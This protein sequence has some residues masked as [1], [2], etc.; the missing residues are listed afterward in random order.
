MNKIPAKYRTIL[1]CTALAIVTIAAFWQVPFY[2]FIDFDDN[3]YVTANP[4]IQK[5]LNWQSVVW[6]FRTPYAA[7]WHPMTMLS[8]MLDYQLF[9]LN[10]FGYHLTNVLLHIANTLLLFIIL[11]EMTG[12][13]WKSAFVAAAFAL[14]SLHV[15]SVAWVSERKDV[16]ST[17]FWMLTMLAYMR[18]A[19]R[20]S[21][22]RYLL[23]L[24]V[25]ALGLMAKPMLVTLPFV[26]LLVD[27]WPLERLQF[28]RLAR[29]QEKNSAD[30]GH[31][32]S[33][34]IL[35]KVPFLALSAVFSVITIFTQKSEQ[36]LSLNLPLITRIGNAM[37]SYLAYIDKMVWPG[38]L[39]VFYPHPGSNLPLWQAAAAFAALAGISALA[40]RLAARHKYLPVGWLLFLGTLVPVIGLVQIHSFAM[41]DRFTYIPLTGLFII[42]AWGADDFLADGRLGKIMLGISAT[43]VLSALLICTSFQLRYWRNNVTL[44]EHAIRVT[45]NN[46]M[47]YYN[48]GVAYSK[49][50]RWQE[51]I[52]AYR[53]STRIKP[54]FDALYNLGNAY[55][56][57][58]RWQEAVEAYKQAIAIKP[59]LAQAYSNLGNSYYNLGRRMEAVEA[60]RQAIALKPD[61][62]EAH[63]NLGVA[64]LQ[65]GDKGSA[66]EECK[67]LKTLDAERAN[68]LFNLIQF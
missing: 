37:V 48:L 57:L 42:I 58:G 53:Q 24:G 25:F 55:S 26:L 12:A 3:V 32:W 36:T 22:S 43:A 46:S 60:Y 39:A 29:E 11:N 4:H 13:L 35:E 10:A 41:A 52:E 20:P 59:D 33:R 45:A 18:Y 23:T 14:H 56:E 9:G 47:A 67:I 50:G 63:Y 51:A 16:L 2:E 6:A 28:N 30:I 31:K 68:K 1:M 62:A 38:N 34:L 61:F 64:Y 15:E 8:Y 65:I 17:L 40:I 5:G 44:F 27:Y 54:A 19:R 49:V 7:F 66:L 21:V